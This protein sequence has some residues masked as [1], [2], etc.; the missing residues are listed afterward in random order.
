MNSSWSVRPVSSDYPGRYLIGSM[1]V[2]AAP[3]KDSSVGQGPVH[4]EAAVGRA[5]RC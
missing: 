3:R 2:G 1:T 4:L 5:A